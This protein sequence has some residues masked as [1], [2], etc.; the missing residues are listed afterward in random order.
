MQIDVQVT[1]AMPISPAR[2]C[3]GQPPIVGPVA[4][5]ECF[6]DLH[7][8]GEVASIDEQVEIAVAPIAGSG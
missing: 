4:V 1:L 7:G 2:T 6:E 8:L 3:F 5:T